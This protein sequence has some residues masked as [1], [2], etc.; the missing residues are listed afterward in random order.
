MQPGTR[1]GHFE[2]FALA[3]TAEFGARSQIWLAAIGYD[4]LI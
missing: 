3:R 4:L 2:T 1:P